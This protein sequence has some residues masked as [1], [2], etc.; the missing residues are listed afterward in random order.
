VVHID[1]LSYLE[2]ISESDLVLGSA[3][4]TATAEAV[5]FGQS[6]T[7]LTFTDSFAKKLQNGG[8]VAIAGGV[9]I[10]IGDNSTASVNVTGNG[11]LVIQIN[12]SKFITSKNAA[13]AAGIVVAID[14]A[15]NTKS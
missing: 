12:G 15:S 6:S 1:D 13:I 2:N 11:N 7:A 5:A 8:S 10:A 9:G 14:F 4:A 3:G